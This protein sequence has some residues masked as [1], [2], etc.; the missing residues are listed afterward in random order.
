[1]DCRR[2][3][4][5]Q[6]GTLPF[7]WQGGT[8]PHFRARWPQPNGAGPCASL[9]SSEPAYEQPQITKIVKKYELPV[10]YWGRG[11]IGTFPRCFA[12]LGKGCVGGEGEA[13]KILLHVGWVGGAERLVGRSPAALG[14]GDCNEAGWQ[15][16]WCMG[17][18]R[19]LQ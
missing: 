18:G 14:G 8:L 4:G 3:L 9:V 2:S 13:A 7:D 10:S 16:F 11:G 5:Y 6:N 17:V 15:K 12:D 1:M 19:P